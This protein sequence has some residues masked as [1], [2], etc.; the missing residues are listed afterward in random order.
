METIV[1]YYRNGKVAEV[2]AVDDGGRKQGPAEEYCSDGTLAYK[3]VY[4]DGKKD[5]PYEQY[6]DNT[7]WEK[8]TYKAGKKDGPCEVYHSNGQLY[9]RTIYTN[10]KKNGPY[11]LYYDNGQ[12]KGKAIYKD[13]K[14]Q[15]P[16]E[17]YSEDGQLIK[18]GIWEEDK[19]KPTKKQLL[20][21]AQQARGNL[22][23]RLKAIAEQIKGSPF[24]KAVQRKEAAEFR[25][26]YPQK[27]A[28]RLPRKK[29]ANDDR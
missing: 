8:G 19:E 2:Y 1:E 9:E 12:L 16:Y 7:L 28:G 25:Q 29:K 15:G 10:G 26:E 22:N 13:D 21:R 20:Q 18:K 3:C 4:K 23:T 11:E 14:M 6:I 24:C 5:G 17:M 27:S